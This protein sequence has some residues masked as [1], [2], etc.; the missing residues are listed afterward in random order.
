MPSPLPPATLA[1][2][3]RL[4]S[5]WLAGRGGERTECRLDY[6]ALLLKHAPALVD[7]AEAINAIRAISAD[8]TD[9]YD[10]GLRVCEVLAALDRAGKVLW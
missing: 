6:Q 4:E 3:R 5:A 10:F 7:A 9:D 8:L 1:D 2:L